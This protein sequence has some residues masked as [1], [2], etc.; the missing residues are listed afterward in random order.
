MNLL[1]K[2]TDDKLA[3]LTGKLYCSQQNFD[4]LGSKYIIA[5]SAKGIEYV[6]KVEPTTDCEDSKIILNRLQREDLMVSLGEYIHLTAYNLKYNDM[7]VMTID[8]SVKSIEKLDGDKLITEF[9]N[10]YS[11]TFAAIN[12]RFI[13]DFHGLKIECKIIDIGPEEENVSFRLI[14]NNTE[15]IL[16]HNP[17]IKASKKSMFSKLG[18]NFDFQSLGIGGLDEEFKQLFRR[19]FSSRMYPNWVIKQLGI[20]YVKGILLHGP[21]GTGKTLI[22]RK[23]G[24]LLGAKEPKIVN[25]PEILSKWV[26]SSEENVRQLFIDAESDY[27][28]YGDDSDLHIIIIDEIDSIV[29]KRGTDPSAS[30]VADRVV[31]QLLTKIDGIEELNNLLLIGMTN[32]IDLIDPAILRPGRL[33]VHIEIGLPDKRGRKQIFE[34]HTAS[35]LQSNRL[36]QVD[37]DKLSEQT[38]NYSGAEI[39]SVVRVAS[40]YALDRGITNSKTITN[41]STVG[42]SEKDVIV[43]MKDFERAIQ[44][45]KPTFGSEKLTWKN[46]FLITKNIAAIMENI[47]KVYNATKNHQL[48]YSVILLRGPARSGK[49]HTMSHVQNN[50]EFLFVRWIRLEDYLEFTERQFILELKSI[51][52]DAERSPTSLI[53]IDNIEA[54]LEYYA[55]GSSG[56]SSRLFQAIQSILKKPRR[57]TTITI[58]SS[59]L[60][61]NFAIKTFELIPFSIEE[62]TQISTDKIENPEYIGKFFDKI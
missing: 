10:Q 20:K 2:K 45:I 43:Y 26:G 23:I 6:Y 28:K 51:Y 46:N 35:M 25:G 33:E 37:I 39:E 62:L 1:V 13:L 17:N 38:K 3:S 40:S 44:E 15:I 29:K 21:P 19:A 31:N 34:I 55:P 4:K 27:M 8:I 11:G 14:N 56:K 36:Q 58:V 9:K 22:A 50:F 24:Q 52:T 5:S 32:R 60:D 30:G 59:T 57:N 54:I 12:Q 41:N 7:A 48:Q 16:N 61:L 47:Q 42:V 53:L 18:P 49:T